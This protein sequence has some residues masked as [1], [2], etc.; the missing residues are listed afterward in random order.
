MRSETY[1][2]TLLPL[3]YTKNNHFHSKKKKQTTVCKTERDKTYWVIF[4]ASFIAEKE[5]ILRRTGIYRERFRK[6][7]FNKIRRRV[8]S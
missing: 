6:E 8:A 7:E 1:N 2:T 5:K 3:K 4:K